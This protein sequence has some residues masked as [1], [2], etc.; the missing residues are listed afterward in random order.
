LVISKRPEFSLGTK[1][2]LE[3]ISHTYNAYR[4]AG[5][6][7]TIE[8]IHKFGSEKM[9][10]FIST[11]GGAMLDYLSGEI[12]PGIVALQFSPQDTLTAANFNVASNP[13]SQPANSPSTPIPAPPPLPNPKPAPKPSKS[14]L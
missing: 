14:K 13:I 9:F 2:I 8:A 10:D 3:A 1:S 7:E 5:G 11:G 6:G 4:V 12:L